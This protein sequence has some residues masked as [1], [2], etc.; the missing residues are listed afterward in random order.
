M[1]AKVI[2]VYLRRIEVVV[3]L[4]FE[5][6]SAVDY[7]SPY[8]YDYR[9]GP[10]SPITQTLTHKNDLLAWATGGQGCEQI[11]QYRFEEDVGNGFEVLSHYMF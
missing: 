6:K 11:L 9:F 10:S 3:K 2:C 5:V 7:L 4:V 8:I 1:K